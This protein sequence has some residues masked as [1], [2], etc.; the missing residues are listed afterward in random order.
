MKKNHWTL[1]NATAM[2]GVVV[3]KKVFLHGTSRCDEGTQGV[4]TTAVNHN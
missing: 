1:V 2:Q 3:N 4:R